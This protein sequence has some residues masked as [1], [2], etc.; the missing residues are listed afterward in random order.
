MND[1]FFGTGAEEDRSIGSISSADERDLEVIQKDE[2]NN[3]FE[4]EK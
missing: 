4:I 3:I 2:Y 1:G